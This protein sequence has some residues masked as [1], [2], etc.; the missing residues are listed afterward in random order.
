MLSPLEDLIGQMSTSSGDQA[1]SRMSGDGV[2]PGRSVEV[3]SALEMMHRNCLRLLK[4]VNSLLDFARIEAGV[5]FV[6][7]R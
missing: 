6:F 7:P 1:T 2:F 5:S 4:L 3:R